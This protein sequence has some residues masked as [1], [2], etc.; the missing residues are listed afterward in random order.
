M[1]GYVKKIYQKSILNI[2]YYSI[3]TYTN[4]L[5]ITEKVQNKLSYFYRS[6]NFFINNIR[7]NDVIE[8]IVDKVLLFKNKLENLFRTCFEKEFIL[9]NA[10]LI[11]RDI[12]SNDYFKLNVINFFNDNNI[13]YLDHK[14]IDL[15]IKYMNLENIIFIDEET[16]LLMEYEI[17]C[18]NYKIIYPYYD[19][20]NNKNE[21]IIA[22]PFYNNKYLENL[23]NNKNINNFLNFLKM[24]CKDIEYVKIND[25]EIKI[26]KLKEFQGPLLDFEVI[27]NNSIKLK[28]FLKE[29]NYKEKFKRFEVKFANPYLDENSIELIDHFIILDNE[30]S[31]IKSELMNKFNN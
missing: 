20:N 7:M 8:L 19:I 1:I 12:N 29:I 9:H 14:I 5:F 13:K 15:I 4:I 27:S 2:E 11:A 25:E 24:N 6:N 28:W 23:K 16:R 31:F 3:Y 21:N 22:Y 10:Y 30:N 26:S 17:K 18:N